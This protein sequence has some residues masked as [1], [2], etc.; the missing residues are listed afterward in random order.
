NTVL[1][2]SSGS[3]NLPGSYTINYSAI[4]SWIAQSPNPFPTQMRAGRIKYYGSIPTQLTGSWP[5]YGGTDQQ[6]WKEVID[7]TLGFRQTGASSY[8]DVSA[9]AGY[10]SDFGWGTTSRN[11][12]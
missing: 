1:F 7:Y 2:N 6:F 8:Q 12:P 10:G 9:M 11:T 4:L 5:S 3:L